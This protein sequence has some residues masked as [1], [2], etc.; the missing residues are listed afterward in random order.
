MLRDSLYRKLQTAPHEWIEQQNEF[1]AY[2]TAYAE[3]EEKHK[4]GIIMVDDDWDPSD[5]LREIL[6]HDRWEFAAEVIKAT[7]ADHFHGCA[8]YL[9]QEFRYWSTQPTWVPY[10]SNEQ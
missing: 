7:E 5:C 4:H 3:L 9:E 2:L 6:N 8:Q 10:S 1:A